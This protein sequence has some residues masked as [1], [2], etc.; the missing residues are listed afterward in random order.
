MS[1]EYIAALKNLK[2]KWDGYLQLQAFLHEDHD[3]DLGIEA[4]E[5]KKLAIE[6]YDKFNVEK[7]GRY[8]KEAMI[9]EVNE[10]QKIPPRQHLESDLI[11]FD[12]TP[13]H[14]VPKEID[15]A[16]LKVETAIVDSGGANEI[17][18][19]FQSPPVTLTFAAE[20][21]G[22]DMTVKKL[23]KSIKS[24]SIRAKKLNRQTY[25]FDT[26]DFSKDALKKMKMS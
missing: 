16:I 9:S 22:G 13:Y 18:S 21:I 17:P 7:I 15:G 8:T 11:D 25:I 6:T 3:E 23:A 24:G 2:A 4:K 14:D 19:E 5:L 20:C 1:R 10:Q 26:Q 12:I